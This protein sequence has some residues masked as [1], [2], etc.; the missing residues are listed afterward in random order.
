MFPGKS[1]VESVKL[2]SKKI[3][4]LTSVVEEYT[5]KTYT[6]F[7]F[8]T[9]FHQ[10]K[11]FQ[12]VFSTEREKLQIS[13]D[14]SVDVPSE[15]CQLKSG[16]ELAVWEYQEKIRAVEER[17]E[18]AKIEREEAFKRVQEEDRLAMEDNQKNV[19]NT[20]APIERQVL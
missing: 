19:D 3:N 8:D 6:R 18:Q 20:H 14:L 17:E 11:L 1:L 10:Y 9:F 2:F 5:L 13:M 16:K 7:Y 4:A 15:P 12:C